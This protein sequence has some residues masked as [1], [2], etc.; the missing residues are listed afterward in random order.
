[1]WPYADCPLDHLF[2]PGL[3]PAGP[4]PRGCATF[5]C[6]TWTRAQGTTN[7]VAR[8]VS[9]VVAQVGILDGLLIFPNQR[10]P[11]RRGILK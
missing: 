10:C 6:G 3:D 9:M 1:M 8:R 11:E 7:G 4:P 2:V 5:L